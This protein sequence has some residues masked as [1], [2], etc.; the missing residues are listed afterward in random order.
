MSNLEYLQTAGI[1]EVAEFVDK[2]IDRFIDPAYSTKEDEQGL[3]VAKIDK[4]K[5]VDWL[6]EE[7]VD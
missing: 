6:A 5:F 4:V 3:V 2:H 7:K 1:V